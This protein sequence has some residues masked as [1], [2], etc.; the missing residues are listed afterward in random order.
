MRFE[1]LY[2]RNDLQWEP[3]EYFTE[4]DEGTLQIPLEEWPE[5]GSRQ[6]VTEYDSNPMNLIN[7]SIGVQ[8]SF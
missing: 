3:A 5:G 8:G 4:Q 1:V 7:W 2:H 6:P